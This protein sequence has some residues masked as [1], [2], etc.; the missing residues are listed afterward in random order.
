M[1]AGHG[2]RTRNIDVQDLRV[3]MRAAQEASVEHPRQRQVIGKLRLAADF[4]ERV[5][6]GQRLADDSEL[7]RHAPLAAASSTASKILT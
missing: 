1:D 5:R 3:R 7:F 6:L 2:P 4:R